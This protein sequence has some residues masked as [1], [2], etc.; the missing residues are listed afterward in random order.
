MNS[1][2]VSATRLSLYG[3]M[4]SY[5]KVHFVATYMALLSSHFYCT[6]CIYGFKM[7]CNKMDY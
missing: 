3:V 2:F 7:L 6:S 1:L 4:H 5:T